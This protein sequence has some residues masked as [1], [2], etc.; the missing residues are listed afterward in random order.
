LVRRQGAGFAHTTQP[1]RLGTVSIK[2]LKR[3]LCLA[4]VAEF[5]YI[6]VSH[7][8]YTSSINRL[9]RLVRKCPFPFGLFSLYTETKTK[10]TKERPLSTTKPK[11][12]GSGLGL[13]FDKE[14]FEDSLF[15]HNLQKMLLQIAPPD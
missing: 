13:I 2:I 3:L 12:L 1:V 9:V 10:Y 11:R 5:R 15:A 14:K 8:V 4:R 6:M 7:S